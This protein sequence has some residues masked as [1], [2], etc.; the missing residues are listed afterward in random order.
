MREEL[1]VNKLRENVCEACYWPCGVSNETSYKVLHE[2]LGLWKTR[3]DGVKNLLLF[4]CCCQRLVCCRWPPASEPPT[5]LLAWL[6]AMVEFFSLSYMKEALGWAWT[7]AA[8]T[9]PQSRHYSQNIFH[10]KEKN[11]RIKY[12]VKL[13][14]LYTLS[15]RFGKHITPRTITF[16]AVLYRK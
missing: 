12:T 10:C 1:N 13:Q 11:N 6:G 8:D 3:P 15:L 16:Y 4:F 2:D 14:F 9:L 5:Q 7:A